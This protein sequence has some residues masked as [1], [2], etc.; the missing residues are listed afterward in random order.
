MLVALDFE[1][2]NERPESACAIGYVAVEAGGILARREILLRPPRGFSWFSHRNVAVHGI[3]PAM[4]SGAPEWPEVWGELAG[5][6]A[7]GEVLAHNTLFD[8]HVLQALNQ[9]YGLPVPDFD[10]LCTCRLARKLWPRLLSYRLDALCARIGFA[11]Q[12]HRA[13]E[14]A[15][16]CLRVY[17]ALCQTSGCADF[18]ALA[19]AAALQPGRW[20]Q[21]VMVSSCRKG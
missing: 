20:R 16:A 19:A 13:G 21:G 17:E 5:Y 2:A 10:F 18:A 8:M 15:L 1:T 7:G 9:A 12:H 3:Q 6:L 14:D 4:V 11:F